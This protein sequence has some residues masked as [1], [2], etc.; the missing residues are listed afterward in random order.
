LKDVHRRNKVGILGPFSYGNLGNA[1]LQES[2][3]RQV[4][5]YLPGSEIYGCFIDPENILGEGAVKP[6]P[7]DR[8]ISVTSSSAMP[9]SSGSSVLEADPP[10]THIWREWAKRL[11]LARQCVYF[12]RRMLRQA[13]SIPDELRFLARAYGFARECRILIVG[14]GGVIDDLW[15]GAWGDPYSLFR[16]ALLARFAGTPFVFLSV[17]AERL[18][19]RLGRFFLRKALR[20]AT[21]R[22]FRD[23]ESKEKVERMGVRGP[24]FIFPD[25]AFSLK[26]AESSIAAQPKGIQRVAAITPMAYCDPRSW[27]IKDKA[28][29]QKYLETLA[30]V[31]GRLLNRGYR[32]SLFAT[33]IRMDSAPVSEL[34]ELI[35]Q[36]VPEGC[37]KQ[38]VETR[39]GGVDELLTVAGQADFVVS[40]RLHGVILPFLAGTP[41]VA[42][43]HSSKI[44]RLMEDMGLEA[45][46]TDIEG[47]DPMR[48]EEQVLAIEAHQEALRGQIRD[49][50]NSYRAALEEQFKTVLGPMPSYIL[51]RATNEGEH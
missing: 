44:N 20:L 38:V 8:T 11:P 51:H 41:V 13:R 14:M 9:T 10:K 4:H 18:E 7:L 40:S 6:F 5:R 45:Y 46:C 43:S 29:Y 3:V 47:S 50:V 16:W 21:Y 17:G 34:K 39:V 42:I 28:R 15:N 26:V 31:A 36:S 24:N 49:K 27:P 19:T 23:Q 33:Q 12:G 25:L 1:A 48:I 22:S 32:I 37:R 35:L 2:V 30:A